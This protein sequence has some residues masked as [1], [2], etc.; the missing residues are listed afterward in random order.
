MWVAAPLPAHY[1]VPGDRLWF[2]NPDDASSDVT[3][4]EGSW[5]FYLGGGLYSN[6]WKPE[7]PYTL[8][9]KCVEIYHWRHGTWRDAQ[10]EL[11]MDEA[12][13][14]ELVQGTMADADAVANILS[15]MMRVQDPKGV[16]AQGGCIDA[17]REYPRRVCAA[18]AD[19][20]LREAASA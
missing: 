11:Q 2:R 8:T 16:Y 13:V 19:L 15:L 5:V 18:T 1:Q 12:R 3:G 14:D 6:F 4:Y 17:S 9:S 20:A 10:G 7:Q